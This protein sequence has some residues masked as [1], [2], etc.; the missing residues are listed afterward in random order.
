M[1]LLLATGL[2]AQQPVALDDHSRQHIFSFGEIE[3]F[4][5]PAGTYTID[6]VT[7][8]A[9]NDHFKV[10]RTFIPKNYHYKSIYWYRIRIRHNQPT[11]NS[12]IIEF[13]DQTIDKINFYVPDSNLRYTEHRYGAIHLFKERPYHHKNVTIDLNSNF[14]GD[15]IYYFSI[16]SRQPA[17]VMVVLKPVSW[18]IQYGLREYF[19]SGIFYGMILV[20]CLYNFVMFLAIRQKQYLY[21]IIYNLSIGIFELSSNGIAYQYLWP[22]APEWNEIAYGVALYIASICALLFTREFLNLKTKAPRLNRLVIGLIIARTVFFLL[23][24]FIDRQWFNYKFIEGIPLLLAFYAGCYVLRKGYSP[25][26]FFVAGYSFLLLGFIIR[27]VKILYPN[28]F[29]FGPANFYSLSIC[30][31][32]EM[33]FVSFAIGDRVRLLKKKKDKAQKRIIHEM[34]V[35]QEL[36]DN[37]NKELEIQVAQRTREVVAQSAALAE[38]SSIIEEQNTELTSINQLLQEQADEITRM[39]ELL[40]QDNQVLQTNIEKVTHARVMSTEVDF[41]EFSK[42]YPDNEACFKFLAELKWENGYGCRKC[43]HS[44][45]FNGHVPYSRRCSKCGYEESVTTGTIFQNTRIPVNK[46]F[47]MV[48]LVYST[49]GKISSH[50]LSEILSIRQGTCWSYSSKIKK[51]LEDRKKE[52]KNAGEKGWSK[53]VLE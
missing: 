16:Q 47:Y 9:F 51:L 5:D 37:L 39:N 49:K 31:I 46:A 33:L 40:A 22:N 8:P 50:K 53:L 45:F 34:K 15:R 25:A 52:V 48:F 17:N 30:F 10:G 3:A 44:Q 29:P 35:N 14:T 4:E 28:N 27:V 43:G 18:F 38:K 36:K 11:S 13:Y 19:Y 12:W 23:C 1:L 20:F 7:A 6:A 26:R 41:T 32:M 42:I 24:L 2:Y 21:Y